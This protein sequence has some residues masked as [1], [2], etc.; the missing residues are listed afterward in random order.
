MDADWEEL[1]SLENAW[2]EAGKASAVTERLDKSLYRE[3]FDVGFARA[4][5][6]AIELSAFKVIV[7]KKLMELEKKAVSNLRLRRRLIEVIQKIDQFPMEN[8]ADFDFAAGIESIRSSARSMGINFAYLQFQAQKS[9]T[10]D[11]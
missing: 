5:E 11:W 7:Q 3:G 4:S 6:L 9:D 10:V 1:N 8:R 2:Y